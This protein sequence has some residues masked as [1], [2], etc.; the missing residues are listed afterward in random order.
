MYSFSAQETVELR[1]RETASST[2]GLR[3]VASPAPAAGL[4]AVCALGHV[5][6][7]GGCGP[8]DWDQSRNFIANLFLPDMGKSTFSSFSFASA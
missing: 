6:R 3:P 7:G 5:R 1:R 4:G 2:A 8:L